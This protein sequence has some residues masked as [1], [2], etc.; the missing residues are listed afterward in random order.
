[1]H[2]HTA[3]NRLLT[4]HTLH[5]V[6]PHYIR[7]KN[8]GYDDYRKNTKE[9]VHSLL[10]NYLKTPRGTTEQFYLPKVLLIEIH[11]TYTTQAS[12][13]LKHRLINNY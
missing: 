11:Y 10:I 1:M 12:R 8:C 5:A 13:D 3:R 7:S 2:M 9:T 4:A 6:S